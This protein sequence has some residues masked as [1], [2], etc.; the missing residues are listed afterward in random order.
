MTLVYR[1]SPRIPVGLINFWGFKMFPRPWRRGLS[2]SQQYQLVL[3][4]HRLSPRTSF[5]LW[6]QA[7]L[8]E[9][10]CLLTALGSEC[11]RVAA[12]L[13][14]D[15]PS[16]A[17]CFCGSDPIVEFPFTI[18]GL[19][20]TGVPSWVSSWAAILRVTEALTMKFDLALLIFETGC[21]EHAAPITQQQQ[22]VIKSC[23]WAAEINEWNSVS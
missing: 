22:R 18:L 23:P 16:R 6:A 9:N 14:T 19:G 12:F 1:D 10:R 4:S 11:A 7:S 2:F 20:L 5:D 13:V 3:K 8:P 21:W 15:Y 17:S